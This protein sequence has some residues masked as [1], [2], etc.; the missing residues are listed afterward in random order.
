MHVSRSARYFLLLMLLV[1][2]VLGYSAYQRYEDI[3][4]ILL[5]VLEYLRVTLLVLIFVGKGKNEFIDLIDDSL[6]DRAKE[7][8]INSSLFWM[9]RIVV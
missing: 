6:I 8:Q 5:S 2:S 1:T 7:E 4:K 3:R 9:K